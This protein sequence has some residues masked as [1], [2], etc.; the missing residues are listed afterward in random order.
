MVNLSVLIGGPN[1]GTDLRGGLQ[2]R[3]ILHRDVHLLTGGRCTDYKGE[4]LLGNKE[5]CYPLTITDHASR[6]LLLCEA[7][8]ST[9]EALAFT[10][11][12]RLFKVRGLPGSIRSDNGVP[13]ASP[14]SLFNL[15]KLSV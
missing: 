6:Y 10:V 13:F 12:A 1:G 8:E 5:Y 9:C 2:S 3:R 11:F 7:L 14:N 15:S 4:F